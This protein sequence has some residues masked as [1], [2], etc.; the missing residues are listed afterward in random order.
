MDVEH[1]V[2]WQTAGNDIAVVMGCAALLVLSFAYDGRAEAAGQATATPEAAAA[3]SQPTFKIRTQRNLVVVRVVVRDT[4]G[5]A[6]GD[7]RK[8][9]FRLL[10]NNR[11][12]II[13]Q[14]AVES[15]VAPPKTVPIGKAA[16][17]GREIAT[18]TA[19][20]S[21]P[22]R[23]VALYFDDIHLSFEDI[24]RTR[25]AAKRYL[26][27]AIQ[28][29]D[30][31]GLF[32]SSGLGDLEFTAER[33]KLNRALDRLMPRPIGNRSGN[34]CPEIYDYQAY[35]MI[36]RRDPFA[37]DIATEEAYHCDCEDL[38]M[39]PPNCR[40]QAEERAESAAYRVEEQFERETEYSLRGLSEVIR[41]ISM[42]PGQRNI[43]LV[44]PGFLTVTEDQEISEIVDEALRSNIVINTLDSQGLFT[45]IPFGDAT[46]RP[47]I[48]VKRADLT[49]KKSQIYLDEVSRRSDV[50]RTLAYDTG[51]VFFH[52]SNDLD[53][54]FRQVGSLPEV[55]YVLAFTPENLKPD[56]RFHTLT[57]SLV[58][59]AKLS[60]EARRGYFAPTVA[61]NAA[62][63][64]DEELQQAV[65]SQDEIGE[66]PIDVETQFFHSVNASI[67]LSVF[68]HIDPRFIH[69]RRQN[70]RNF[71]D[72]TV[73]TALFD[74]AGKYIVGQQKQIEFHLHDSTLQKL[75]ESGIV[76]KTTFDVK[77]GTYLV[78]SVVRDAAG[79]QT[80]A[81]NRSVEIP[82][83]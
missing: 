26:A 18:S 3:N 48:L 8:E 66:I 47:L 2:P 55:Y 75:R 59:P 31:I 69:F 39:I 4:A 63:V 62:T 82:A 72:L 12:Q 37:L 19:P 6:V 24:S 68:T 74:G 34:E 1:Q 50:L 73:V 27:T 71:D 28:P 22:Q 78:R 64:A 7:L 67:K 14:F 25:A 51:G 61:A 23:F 17:P 46:R 38:P 77:P 54:G 33:T 35:L 10:D 81:L 76:M 20:G 43:V 70:G 15:L 11:P 42:V 79:E 49:G 13:S 5:R 29:G 36:H 40:Q 56:G 32:T 21:A 30:R 58:K 9:D 57:V 52:N 44:S 41:H 60:L 45:A 80:S 83:Q 65:F 16:G 53:A